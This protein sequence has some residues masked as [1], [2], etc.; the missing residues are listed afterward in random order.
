M[1]I[2]CITL[3]T[4]NCANEEISDQQK[5]TVAI[6]KAQKWFNAYKATAEFHPA[7]KN[8]NYY[9]ENAS[10]VKLENNSIAITIPMKD[11][12]ENPDYHGKK[13]LYLYPADNGYNTVVHEI[14]PKSETDFGVENKKE[15]FQNLDV[16]TGYILTWN[17]T[18][19]FVK[20]AEFENG[21]AI[22]NISYAAILS[23]DEK[24]KAF[25]LTRKAPPNWQMELDSVIVTGGSGSGGCAGCGGVIRI[26]PTIGGGGTGGGTGD[27]IGSPGA[28]GDSSSGSGSKPIGDPCSRIREQLTSANFVAKQDELKKKTNLKVET[29]YLQSKNG[30]FTALN[31]G[32][33]TDNTD[34]LNFPF[35]ANTI[36]YIHAHLDPYEKVKAN[37]DIDPVEPIRMHSPEDVKQF[38]ILILN[39]GRNSIPISEVYGA[40]VSSAGTYQL[41]FTGNIADV[42]SK[43]SSINW[44]DGLDKTYTEIMKKSSSLEKGFLKFLNEQIGI[45][46][47][48]LYKIESSGNSKKTLDATGKVTSSNCK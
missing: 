28:G 16:F 17:L 24:I 39:A 30:P 6:D 37:G 23:D 18:E 12:P 7:F 20:G 22:K 3:L 19:G 33:G 44:G 26:N 40:M 35:D 38:I 21:V 13:M 5:T 32:S 46:G 41:R 29:G 1:L 25:N 11:N 15:D 43:A 47:I 8:I 14:F 45:N 31:P 36:G 27:Y 48:E 10:L 4:A 34:S 42:S 9:W 2:L